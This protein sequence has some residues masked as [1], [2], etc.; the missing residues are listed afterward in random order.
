MSS[1]T[2]THSLSKLLPETIHFE[3]IGVHQATKMK[4]KIAS[5]VC[6]FV[7]RDFSKLAPCCQAGDRFV[8]AEEIRLF[9]MFD[10]I[11]HW[12]SEICS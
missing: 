12:L 3:K 7:A 6:A 10:S 4:K 11:C 2:V 5:D 9:D 1:N 8:S